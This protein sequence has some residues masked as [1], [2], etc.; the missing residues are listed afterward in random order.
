MGIC[1]SLEILGIYCDYNFLAKGA[2]GC[3]HQF[4]FTIPKVYPDVL[5]QPFIA[6]NAIVDSSTMFLNASIM[7]PQVYRLL[8]MQDLSIAAYHNSEFD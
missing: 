3:G 5:K 4:G 1:L 2:S 7:K 8:S 6:I